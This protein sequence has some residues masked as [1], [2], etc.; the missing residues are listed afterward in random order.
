MDNSYFKKID[1]E[2]NNTCIFYTR[3]GDVIYDYVLAE[4]EEKRYNSKSINSLNEHEKD[5]LFV[6]YNSVSL[7]ELESSFSRWYTIMLDKGLD[8]VRENNIYPLETK[9]YKIINIGSN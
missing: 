1:Y 5:Y 3:E 4:F 6:K 7:K 2:E 9:Y 8:Y